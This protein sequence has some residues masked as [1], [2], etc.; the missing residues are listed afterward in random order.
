MNHILKY[1]SFVLFGI[2]IYLLLRNI[3]KKE[4]FSIGIQAVCGI[5]PCNF[6][7][8]DH[9]LD[10]STCKNPLCSP[11][12]NQYH[13]QG[14]CGTCSIYALASLL[15]CMY[16]IKNA[17]T[18]Q[19]N[20]LPIPGPISISP[21][22]ILDIFGRYIHLYTSPSSE[23]APPILPVYTNYRID[24][25]KEFNIAD[26]EYTRTGKT[27]K[28]CI[29]G[30]YVDRTDGTLHQAAVGS[31][32]PPCYYQPGCGNRWWNWGMSIINLKNLYKLKNGVWKDNPIHKDLIDK[33]NRNFHF[34]FPLLK[35]VPTRTNG[36]PYT[37]T[38]TICS[39]SPRYFFNET[40]DRIHDPNYNY[41][42]YFDQE[43]FVDFN[44]EDPQTFDTDAGSIFPEIMRDNWGDDISL[45]FFKETVKQ[46]LEFGPLLTSILVDLD[47][48]GSGFTDGL[49]D[50]SV[51]ITHPV[52]EGVVRANHEFLLIGYSGDNVIILNSWPPR[53]VD[54]V[55]PDSLIKFKTETSF[56]IIYDNLKTNHN[57]Y[58]NLQHVDLILPCDTTDCHNNSI[59]S[60]IKPHCSCTCVD[61]YTGDMCDIEPT[62]FLEPVLGTG[63]IATG[64]G[65]F[66]AAKCAARMKGN[67]PIPQLDDSDYP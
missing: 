60:G 53:S 61:G 55:N 57:I 19:E 4:R 41:T 28:I 65:L 23:Q 7:L 38:I 31:S 35:K 27:C 18:A 37:E 33:M 12:I 66:I 3:G 6:S 63:L 52:A 59:P 44:I 13:Y 21:Q 30:T 15:E 39:L 17:T 34:P 62:S 14:E 64:L 46:Y 10:W 9:E 58:N 49:I 8:D 29:P 25:A 48:D 26:F 20:G 51:D 32:T 42:D 24:V 45:E 47:S 43:S 2:I 56:R 50:L 22:S 11:M 5:I 36:T 16:N 1:L 67:Q 54:I 40:H